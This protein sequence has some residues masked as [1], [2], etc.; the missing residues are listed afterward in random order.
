MELFL[1]ILLL[2]IAVVLIVVVLMQ[3]GNSRGLGA[4]SG[5]ADTFFGKQK[6]KSMAGMLVKATVVLAIL[7]VILCFCL[8][9]LGDKFDTNDNDAAATA[10][11]AAVATAD[12]AVEAEA[13]VVEDVEAEVEGETA[14]EVVEDAEVAVEA[15]AE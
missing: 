14:T 9:L 11:S 15:E 13:E 5:G 7:F 6:G 12:T 4:I 3:E 8:S 1:G 10:E 2:L